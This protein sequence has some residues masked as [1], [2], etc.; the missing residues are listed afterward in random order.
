MANPN[1]ARRCKTTGIASLHKL[2]NDL[3]LAGA[4]VVWPFET[5]WVNKA[6][7]LPKHVFVLHAEIYPSIRDPMPDQI[8]DRGQVRSMWHWARDLDRDDLLWREFYRR[9]EVEIGSK[10]DLAAQLT[11][12]GCSPTMTNQ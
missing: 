3:Q 5:G 8:K 9:V 6:K 10:E 4:S 2:R 12:L 11:D 7:W 1:R